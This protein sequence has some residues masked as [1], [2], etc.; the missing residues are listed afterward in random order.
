[1]PATTDTVVRVTRTDLLD[2]A[3]V[4]ELAGITPDSAR[5]YHTRA[6]ANRRKGTPKPGDLPPPDITIANRPAWQ[7]DTIEKW[8]TQRRPIGRPR[9]SHDTDS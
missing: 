1:M 5:T 4:A 8:L 3:A 7:R 2:L 9:T 6:T